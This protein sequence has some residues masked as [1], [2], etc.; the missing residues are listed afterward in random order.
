MTSHDVVAQVRRRFRTRAVGHT[1]TL[2]PFATGLL[3]L[4]LGGATRLARF[5]EAERKVYWAEARLGVATD[6]D[7]LTGRPLGEP[8][9]G[10]W[11]TREA[12]VAALTGMIGPSLQRPPAYS[13][14]QVGGERSHR[15]ARRGGSLDLAPAAVMIHAV[16]LL[17]YRPPVLVWRA[18]VGPGTY[19]RAMA[20]DLGL[21]L[22][23]GGHLTALRREA[24]GRFRVEA[25]SSL[26]QLT[27]TEALIAPAALVEHL[28][29]IEVGQEDGARL[30]HGQRV[31][32]SEGAAGPV[33]LIEG[34]HLVAIGEPRDGQWHP[35][36]VLAA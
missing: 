2:D 26:D 31:G 28:P 21:V 18:E 34:G 32:S 17:E 3:V 36:V 33:A 6:S 20:R 27:G 22:G 13:A 19:L 14:K 12:V 11:P 35:I 25:A 15:V 4:V 23:T 29:R 1:G 24:V 5:V 9:S 10:E 30:R 8:W 16:T 7:D